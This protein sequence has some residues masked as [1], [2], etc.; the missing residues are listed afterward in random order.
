[1]SK[2]L[3][4]TVS[5]VGIFILGIVAGSLQTG[6]AQNTSVIG[7]PYIGSGAGSSD[8]QY[9]VI[10]SKFT[11]NG[12]AII[13]SMSAYMLYSTTYNLTYH[14]R[15]AI[16]RDNGGS[17]GTLVSQTETGVF[18]GPE[19]GP[20]WG[21]RTANFPQSVQLSSGSYWLVL[22][23]DARSS[24][25][26]YRL[27][28]SSG[29]KLLIST[30]SSLDYP[31]SLPS[32]THFSSSEFVC[33]IY[34][35]GAMTFTPTPSPSPAPSFTPVPNSTVPT[36][37]TTPNQLHTPMLVVACQSAQTTAGFEVQIAGALADNWS[38]MAYRTVEI[39]YSNSGGN[40]W[41]SITSA[42]TG[43]D[44]RFYAQWYPDAAGTY[45]IKV[46]Y[47][48]DPTH[49]QVNAIV[50]IPVTDGASNSQNVFSVASNSTVSALMFNS[51]TNQLNF[52]V[53]GPRGTA[54]Y[55]DITIA[56]SLVPD[57]SAIKTY[58]D[59][60]LVTYSVTFAEESLILH[61]TYHHST[62][63]IA[64][65]LDENSPVPTGTE[66]TSVSAPSLEGDT[67]PLIA[68]AVV[69]SV[70]VVVMGVFLASRKTTKPA[71]QS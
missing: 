22:M 42:L 30:L 69:V 62:H 41:E 9:D 4:L 56:K 51:Q 40:T 27:E 68:G 13:N 54:G 52:V 35:S 19:S 5:L 55:V 15:F 44:G 48:G 7:Y 25:T 36:A 66:G 67:L 6:L 38:P 26:S 12:E 33:C 63:N 37:T 34:A 20:K 49:T 65:N 43:T 60:E 58:F 11:L 61:F 47:G 17:V 71:N 57:V 21:W 29:A 23:D 16:Y 45:L 1:M 8:P 31:T 53:T 24:N 10:G 59:G 14:Y 39:A 3:P 28:P 46:S 2:R 70:V 18:S 32:N 64:V 50:T